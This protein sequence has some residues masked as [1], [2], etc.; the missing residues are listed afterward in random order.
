V[1]LQIVDAD[2]HATDGRT[3]GARRYAAGLGALGEITWRFSSHI[4]AVASVDVEALMP[5]LQFAAGGPDS[6]D[7]GWVQF[8]FSAGL[9]FSIP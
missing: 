6:T 1:S 9:L 2:A 3:G 8:G 4:G 5:R 7:L